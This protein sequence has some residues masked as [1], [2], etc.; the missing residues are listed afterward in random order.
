[1]EDRRALNKGFRIGKG[2]TLSILLSIIV[3]I[4]GCSSD[5]P[6]SEE[7]SGDEFTLA[8][9]IERE[10]NVNVVNNLVEVATWDTQ[11]NG[12]LI[13]GLNLDDDDVL[14]T[15]ATTGQF[16]AS[17]E[18]DD[19]NPVSSLRLTN[20]DSIP[21]SIRI[22]NEDFVQT[23]T[24]S[25]APANC[26]GVSNAPNGG[27][28]N[29]TRASWRASDARLSVRGSG[30]A[31][32]DIV[33]VMDATTNQLIATDQ[34]NAFGAW[35]VRVSDLP[36]PPCTVSV[37]TGDHT[38]NA[39]VI[40]APANCSQAPG[41]AP[42]Q[43][44]LNNQ[45]PNSLIIAPIAD[46]TISVGETVDFIGVGFDP[47]G[48]N[49]LMYSWDFDDAAADTNTQQSTV[50]FNRPGVFRVTLSVE[51]SLGLEDP[52][53][54]TRVIVVEP[55]PSNNLPP[56]GVI[57]SPLTHMEIN[58]G[59]VV[60]FQ[61]AGSDP[62]G[63]AL[64]YFWNFAGGAPNSNAQSPGDVAFLTPGFYLASLTVM[65]ALGLADP[66]PVFRLI[67]VNA[68]QGGANNPNNRAPNGSILS[69]DTNIIIGEGESVFF[70]GTASDPDTGVAN[71][72]YRWN[73]ANGAAD[74]TLLSPGF[75]P[76]N[77]AGV[78]PVTFTVTDSSGLA[79]PTPAQVTVTVVANNQPPEG[80]ITQPLEDVTI[81]AGQSVNFAGLGVDSDGNV[82]LSYLWNFSNVAGQSVQQNPGSIVFNQEGVYI[83]SLTV[84]D[85][86]GLVDPVPALRTVTVLA[87][88]NPGGINNEPPLANI[89]TPISNTT[90]VM[91]QSVSF[92][93]NATDPENDLPIAYLWQ[94]DGAA[95][96]S[97]T[98]N[99]GDV[100]F[101]QAGSYRVTLRARDNNGNESQSPAER[102]ITVINP[103]VSNAEPAGTILDPMTSAMTIN[104]GDSVTFSGMASDPNGNSQFAYLWDF[105]GGAENSNAQSPGSVTFE[106][107]G[108]YR[109]RLFVRDN[110]NL[111]DSTPDERIIT[112]IGNA[113]FNQAPEAKII[114]PTTDVTIDAGDSLFFS[115]NAQDSDSFGNF[116]YIWNFGNGL[117]S[118]SLQEP[119]EIQFTQPGSYLVSLSVM[120]DA[121]KVDATP[122]RRLITVRD[123]SPANIAPVANILSPASNANITLGGSLNFTATA[124]DANSESLTYSW[125]FDGAA[126]DSTVL[127][128]GTINFNKPGQFTVSLIVTDARGKSSQPDTV[129]VNVTG[130]TPLSAQPPNGSISSPISDMQISVGD[131]LTFSGSATD[132]D[133]NFPIDYR[134]YFDG[135]GVANYNQNPGNVTFTE[136]GTYQIRLKTVDNTGAADPTPEIRTISVLPS[137]GSNIPPG[138]NNNLSPNGLITSPTSTVIIA[139][140]ELV[141]FS[142]LGTDPDN[143][144]PLSY[145]WQFGSGSGVQDR[146]TQIPGNIAFNLAGT[147]QVSL[148]V[149]DSLGAVDST[150]ALVTVIVS[151]PNNNTNLAPN[152]VINT[153]SSTVSITQG[154]S[155]S[156]TSTGSDPDNNTP[157]SY[158]WRF[159]AG[160]QDRFTQNPG[161]VVFNSAGTYQVSLTVTDSLGMVDPTPATVTVVVNSATSNNIAPNSFINSPSNAV[162]IS[163]GQS[164]YF[165]GSATD[166]EGDTNLTYFW[167][168]QGGASNSILETPGDIVFNTA[169][170]FIVN[171]TATDSAGLSDE[172]PAIRVITVLP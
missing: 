19:D 154:D 88:N 166:P 141:N 59:D 91:G 23:I 70:T 56:S 117:P 79:D 86:L 26:A 94:F 17:T 73:F 1:M 92:T 109:V 119:G 136:T 81:V 39:D 76:F 150:P 108:T 30:A 10:A 63:T 131:T 135:A 155:V 161:Q 38:V 149:T 16:I 98:Q 29:I 100:R 153:P 5:L 130:G 34:A 144:T 41:Q 89:L 47:D 128:P 90:I 87:N 12:L 18:V 122:E 3:V 113:S 159:G 71:L 14:V 75:I 50:M 52:T 146:F 69:P 61:A 124:T 42:G 145:R 20:L 139:A 169:G 140:G 162:T 4:T 143:N 152:G 22:Q 107:A 116:I 93:A 53:P 120:D 43:S 127:N 72:N 58:E 13:S 7:A 24:V 147:Y 35:R 97:V 158:R 66:T 99:P 11:S 21:C 25:N 110:L 160:I 101:D 37:S 111:Y 77:Q 8:S 78:Y 134:W 106:I 102:I 95:A 44:P 103:G 55:A 40:N 168:F 157:L 121:G 15:N 51:D 115:G 36:I 123:N 138:N 163:R 84:T 170:Q 46:M 27:N 96:D 65:D 165:S 67:I 2:F 167:N 85:S 129:L 33:S 74:S 80:L 48:T 172:T 112:V 114:S 83:V 60:N 49:P 6:D 164:V 137:S 171:F 125:H 57:I 68:V 32:R 148:T 62:E 118:S 105:D 156:F 104:V 142:G 82:P 133:N 54:D 126:A 9:R 151:A 31:P 45:A 132:A 28:L 64:Q